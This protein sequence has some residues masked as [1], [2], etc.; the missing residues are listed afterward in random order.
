M[1]VRIPQELYARMQSRAFRLGLSIGDVARRATYWGRRHPDDVAT[2]LI[3]QTATSSSDVV[4]T[5][6]DNLDAAGSMLRAMIRAALDATDA[7][8][9]PPPDVSA[10]ET[11]PY[12]VVEMAP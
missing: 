8:M 1:K 9:A 2:A 6:P 3:A 12:Q 7:R 10:E 5:L 11:E 4:A